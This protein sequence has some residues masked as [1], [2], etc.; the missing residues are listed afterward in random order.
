MKPDQT[1]RAF[2]AFVRA[3]GER[4]RRVMA[5][6]YGVDI[7]CESADA[8]L[9]WAWEHWDRLRAISN[10]PGYLYRVAQTQARRAI[11]RGRPVTYP[12]EPVRAADAES[13]WADGDLAEA[14]RQLPERQRVTVVLVHVYDWTPTEVAAFIGAP[15]VTVRSHLR[16]GLRQLRKS[17]VKGSVQ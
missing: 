15:A 7:G 17:L 16:R 12:S 11:G 9:A 1:E 14:L 3:D 10:P 5:S 8:A 4:L 2:D 13:S 6:Q